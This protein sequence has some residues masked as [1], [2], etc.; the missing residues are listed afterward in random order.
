MSV[1]D[2]VARARAALDGSD[3]SGLGVDRLSGG[4]SHAVF[5]PAED[6]A[7]VVKVFTTNLR[8]EPSREW[9]ALVALAGTGLAP[10]P[11][12]FDDGD[13]AVVVMTRVAGSSLPAS[14]LDGSHAAVL[15]NA[16][17]RVHR[18]EPRSRRPPSHAWVRDVRE[19]LHRD[20][21]ADR[22]A[23]SD[24]VTGAWR[25]AREWVR[26][27]DIERVLSGDAV[28]FSRGDP[29]LTNY[30]W[31]GDGVVL[32]D[33][34]DSG[35]NDPVVEFADFAEHASS[36]DL[37]D[38]FLTALA[39]GSGLRRSDSERV[40]NARRAMACFWLVLIASRDRAGLPTTVT[41]EDQAQRTL[42]A[43]GL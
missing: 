41:L 2:L 10:E 33:W 4:M 14:A 16:H 39:D 23:V 32:I 22:A 36:R 11:V 37:A 15:G 27:V 30:L 9:E 12:H 5:V 3:Q 40:V 28:C 35:L 1:R 38:D 18:T 42:E 17:R 7:L 6:P 43:L 13:R 31:A 19:S 8:D 21:D 34:E 25:A 24:V 20:I 26:E 29:N